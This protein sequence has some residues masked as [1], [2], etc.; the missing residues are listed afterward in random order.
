SLAALSSYVASYMVSVR[1]I[2]GLPKASFG[3]HITMDTLAVGYVLTTTRSHS[4][5]A[6]VR[7]RPCWANQKTTQPYVVWFFSIPYYLIDQLADPL[8]GPCLHVFAHVVFQRRLSHKYA[9]LRE[10]LV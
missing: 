10:Q 9:L 1:Q 8:T 7:V 2:R 4:G 3:F 5:L 6:P